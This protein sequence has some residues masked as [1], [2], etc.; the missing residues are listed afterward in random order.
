VEITARTVQGRYLLRPSRE[1]NR[2]IVGVLGRA[3]RMT[4]MKVHAVAIMSNHVHYLVTPTSADQLV[5]FMQFVQGNVAREVSD[6]HHWSG[7][8]WAR[9]YRHIEVSDED[10]AHIARL[11]YVLAH[12]VKEDLVHRAYDWPGVHSARALVEG[13]VLEGVWYDRT[14]LTR[15]RHR[16]E[17]LEL[18]DVAEVETLTLSPLPCWEGLSA[19][20]ARA[21]VVAMV[22]AIDQAARE[23]RQADKVF[24]VGRRAV[25]RVHP[26]ECPKKLVWSPAPQFHTATRE[27]WRA[28]RDA[29]VEFV[30]QFRWAADQL[31]DGV[32]D[33]PFPPGSFPPG[34]PFV[35]HE[36]PG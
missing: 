28:L 13:T 22:E 1:L 23:R 30:V 5:R 20:E 33:P 11:R 12:G 35:A 21:Q 17:E 4:G 31:R 15:A 7:P 29:Y 9:R 19:E 2:R 34:L 27:A 36:A 8:F 18:D 26:H 3:Q 6:L 10:D 24:V 32:R 16:S 14:E 25:R